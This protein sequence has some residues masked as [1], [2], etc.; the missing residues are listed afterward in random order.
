MEVQGSFTIKCY[1]IIKDVLLQT[2][3]QLRMHAY[4]HHLRVTDNMP[5]KRLKWNN[6]KLSDRLIQKK[7]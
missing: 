5:P 7:V 1:S 3:K 4:T 2:L 6:E